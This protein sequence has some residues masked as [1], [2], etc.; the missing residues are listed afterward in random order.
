MGSVTV[1][2]SPPNPPEVQSQWR[3]ID[4]GRWFVN[5]PDRWSHFTAALLLEECSKISTIDFWPSEKLPWFIF[6]FFHFSPRSFFLRGARFCNVASLFES[7][8]CIISK[9]DGW[10]RTTADHAFPTFT[11]VHKFCFWKTSILQKSC[12]ASRT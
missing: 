6:Y 4:S 5:A 11:S 7:M 12:T 9:E 10:V 8:H 1:N 3:I 2:R